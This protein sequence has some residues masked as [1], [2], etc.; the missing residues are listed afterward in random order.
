MK[1]NKKEID[2]ANKKDIDIENKKE[3]KQLSKS[4]KDKERDRKIKKEI[5]R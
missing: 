2:I 4:Y 1:K 3:N 5:E